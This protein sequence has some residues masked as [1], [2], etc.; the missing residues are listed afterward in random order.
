LKASFG[1]MAYF[2]AASTVPAWIAKSAHALTEM[3]SNDRILV[4]VQQ[5][6]GNDGLNTVIPYTD[7]YY[8]DATWRPNLHITTGLEN[9]VLD[10]ANAL[11]P[12]MVRLKD[13]WDNGNMAIIQNVGYPNPNLSHFVATDFWEF[14]TSP[15]SALN[16]AIE[17]TKG[18][19][20]R[21]FDNACAG[22]PQEEINPLSMAATGHFLVPK[23]LAGSDRYTPP[24]IFDFNFYDIPFPGV[25]E[26][27]GEFFHDYG[28][29]LKAYMDRLGSIPAVNGEADF[30]QRV[31]S[32]ATASIEDVAIASGVQPLE[33]VTYGQGQ[34]GQGLDMASRMIRG[35][36]NTRIYYVSQGGYDTHA[37]QFAGTDPIEQGD[38][39]RLLEE[40][41]QELHN[42]LYEMSES[43]N[44]DRVLMLSF[45]EFGRRIAENG[46]S[47]T[48][49][50]AGNCLFA[51]G[52]PIEKGV[53]G[54]Q[55]QI[56]PD[57]VNLNNGSLGFEIDFRAVY[58]RVINDWLAG[59]AE[60]VF[61][62]TDWASFDLASHVQEIPFIK[63][64]TPQQPEPE[65]INSDGDV[66]ATD[67]QLV[68]NG[69]LGIPTNGADTDVNDDGE[70]NATDVQRVINA[71]LG[72]KTSKGMP[73][74]AVAS[75]GRKS[76][77][78]A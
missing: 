51:L 1:S 57:T 55:P 23:T 40:F 11:H 61:G 10:E 47:G 75:L 22:I 19:V 31:Y 60:A 50:G 49:H 5:A 28:D 9:T 27:P 4:I 35:G 13:W 62:E 77:R 68:V 59:D 26:K 71:A 41:D 73:K 20:G 32:L 65:D 34:L 12:K 3:V 67:V 17:G 2:S 14:G 42:F 7:P 53:Y 43:G 64:S 25:D 74:S 69:A 48:D 44:L 36:L 45:S 66:D 72:I 39:P 6:G 76:R 54:G 15:G 78:S 46:S 18:W 33:G 70:T 16:G 30:L 24:A 37:N 8:N 56:D 63:D 52:G 38:H 21:Y 29:V 58:A